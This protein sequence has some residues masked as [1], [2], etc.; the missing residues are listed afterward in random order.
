M[1]DPQGIIEARALREAV[2]DNE[3]PRLCKDCARAV[4]HKRRACCGNC[5][6]KECWHCWTMSEAMRLWIG[7]GTGFL[8]FVGPGVG[9]A[10]EG[11]GGALNVVAITLWITSMGSFIGILIAALINAEKRNEDR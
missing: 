1:S 8:F 7:A 4:E 3:E 6:K 11:G 5:G 9:M 10:L 2:K